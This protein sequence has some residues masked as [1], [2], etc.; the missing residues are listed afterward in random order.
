MNKKDSIFIALKIRKLVLKMITESKSS[1]IGSSFSVIDIL[2]V[3]YS[4]VLRI[5]P[6]TYRSVE[7]DYFILSKGHGVA[8]MYATLAAY[9]FISEEELT[10]YCQ[11]DSRLFGHVTA[12]G[13]PGVELS[14]GSLGHGLPVASG[15]AKAFKLDKKSNRVFVLL[16][17]GECDEGTTWESALFCAHHQL[18]NVNMIV[19]YNKLQGLGTVEEIMRLEPFSDKWKAFGWNVV[20]IDGHDHADIKT[21]LNK[22]N[23]SNKPTI[24]IAHTVKGR[25]VG[26]ME[27]KLQWHYASPNAEQFNLAQK[28][29]G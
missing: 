19:D 25:G 28:E 13:V 9:G 11:N 18:D 16:S 29:L 5:S 6:A 24:I 2:A 10:T 22:K 27:N 17:D 21:Q 8:A 7:R 12:N 3:L 26:F 15:I 1:H 20:E 14:T 4:D 23:I